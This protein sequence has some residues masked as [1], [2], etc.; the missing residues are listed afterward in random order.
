MDRTWIC[1]RLSHEKY[2]METVN[3]KWIIRHPVFLH[4]YP[5]REFEYHLGRQN[6]F[7]RKQNKEGEM[8]EGKKEEKRKQEKSKRKRKDVPRWLAVAL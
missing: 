8:G 2:F 6:R 7:L 5:H 4:I 1:Q 3:L